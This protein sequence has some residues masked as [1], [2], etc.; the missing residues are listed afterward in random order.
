VHTLRASVLIVV[1]QRSK[2]KSADVDSVRHARTP[3]LTACTQEVD[4]EQST[5][6]RAKHRHDKRWLSS[7]A[8]NMPGT[9]AFV[10]ADNQGRSVRVSARVR[11]LRVCACLHACAD[12]ALCAQRLAGCLRTCARRACS[13]ARSPSACRC[14]D[15]ADR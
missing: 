5:Y 11:L 12:V 9:E 14:T 8:V 4:D 6:A 2:H 15:S 3:V 7:D 13:R 10:N 1:M